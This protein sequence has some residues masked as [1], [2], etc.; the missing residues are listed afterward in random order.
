METFICTAFVR[1]ETSNTREDDLKV[2]PFKVNVGHESMFPH[3]LT[4]TNKPTLG[5]G[6]FVCLCLH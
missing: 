2:H 6:H 4:I 3:L 1:E 5:R